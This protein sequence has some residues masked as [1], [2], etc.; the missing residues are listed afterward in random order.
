[1]GAHYKDFLLQCKRTPRKPIIICNIL[2]NNPKLKCYVN[3]IPELLCAALR[4]RRPA[5]DD[6]HATGLS[7]PC[8]TAR[9]YCPA[10]ARGAP[11]K[12]QTYSFAGEAMNACARKDELIEILL[13]D[14]E[15][16][17]R[18]TSATASGRL[19]VRGY[20]LDPD[21]DAPPRIALLEAVAPEVRSGARCATGQV[22]KWRTAAAQ[23]ASGTKPAWTPARSR[24]R[25]ADGGRSGLPAGR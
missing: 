12:K 1:M 21:D 14:E 16:L 18:Q 4:L 13:G 23:A 11:T 6:A 8:N 19:I 25:L 17:P 7:S 3:S 9:Q 20:V 15:L 2:F 10:S 24:P 22:W 5:M